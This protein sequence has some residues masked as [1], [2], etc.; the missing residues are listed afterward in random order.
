MLSTRYQALPG[1]ADP[2]ALPLIF[3]PKSEAEPLNIGSQAESGNQLTAKNPVSEGFDASVLWLD[4]FVKI[5][6]AVAVW[7]SAVERCSTV[8]VFVDVGDGNTFGFK[9]LVS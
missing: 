3:F 6:E 5:L 7:I 9:V 2:E 4:R 1:N 8:A